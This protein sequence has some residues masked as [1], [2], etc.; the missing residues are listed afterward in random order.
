MRTIQ[1]HYICDLSQRIR[2]HISPNYF[3]AMNPVSLAPYGSMLCHNEANIWRCLFC[4][5]CQFG[6]ETST[7]E[8][9]WNSHG[10]AMALAMPWHRHGNAMAIAVATM[11]Q[12]CHGIA[13]AMPWQCH[14]IAMA[15]PWQC[16]GNAMAMPWQCHGIAMALP[17][18]GNAMAMPWQKHGKATP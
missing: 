17:W 16:H 15:I 18:H 3:S 12:L 10:K 9:F 14:G 7:T 13:M 4:L 6:L 11:P 8:T 2:C 1:E 5:P